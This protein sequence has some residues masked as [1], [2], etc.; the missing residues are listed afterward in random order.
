[1]SAN[2]RPYDFD[3]VK[4]ATNFRVHRLSFDDGF[5]VLQ[6]DPTRCLDLIDEREDY[7]EERW[8]RI[9]PHPAVPLL[10]IH[11]TWTPRGDV[12][13]LISVR[14]ASRAE[15]YRHAHRYEESP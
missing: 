12:P 10:L 2:G 7:E 8:V 6:V 14:K 5:Q 4:A 13:R 1:M 11:V 9:G 15:R 3:P